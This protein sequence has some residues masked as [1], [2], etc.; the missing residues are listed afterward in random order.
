[1]TPRQNRICI[2]GLSIEHTLC[3][4]KEFEMWTTAKISLVMV[5]LAAAPT[6]AQNVG[7]DNQWNENFR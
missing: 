2:D 4:I 7:Y 6:A 3:L 1:M 5:L